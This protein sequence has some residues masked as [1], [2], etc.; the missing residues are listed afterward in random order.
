MA[1]DG[2]AQQVRIYS[3]LETTPVLT[4]LLGQ[5]G[6]ILADPPGRFGNLRFN[7]PSAVGGDADGNIYVAS[8]GQ[9]GGG[10]TVLES[11]TPDGKL[12]WRLFGME[13]VD[14]ADV[15]PHSDQDV[16]TK[17]E[18]FHLDHGGIPGKDWTYQ[19]YTVDRFKY[20]DD[21]RIHLWSAG[22]WV[23]RIQDRRVLF[24]LDMNNQWLQVYR[25]APE[26]SGEIAIPSGLFAPRHIREGKPE[27]WPRN[28]PA[29]RSL[30][31]RDAN[32]DGILDRDEFVANDR[33]DLPE[34][35][36]W[37]VDAAGN[38]WLATETEGVLRFP[39]QGLDERGNPKWDFRS[40]QQ[41]AKP[42]G[43]DK[44]KR[45]RYDVNSDTMYLGGHDQRA[46]QPALEAD[47]PGDRPLRS[48]G[49]WS[50]EAAVDD[51]RTLCQGLA[52]PRIVRADGL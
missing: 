3:Q 45:L 38:V 18:H 44:V 52:G 24:V 36:G 27:G 32:G 26:S 48:L 47:G 9:T 23:R 10:G 25:F 39:L 41:F 35:Q 5:P 33:L 17:E 40:R 22:V 50:P 46:H 15:D 16:F 4:G 28:Q 2:P 49:R 21:P 13:F 6:G 43:F 42:S 51:R 7:H 20:P 31:L 8:D 19:G 14:M 30:D 37:W 12:R 11:Y 29:A 34:A 1:D